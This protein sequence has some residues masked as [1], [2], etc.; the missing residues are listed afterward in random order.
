MK[1]IEAIVKPFR[2]EAVKEALTELGVDGMTMLDVK[3]FGR[4]FGHTEIYR[5]TEYEVDFVPK[6]MIIVVVPD[7]LADE[8]IKAILKAAKTGKIGDGKIFVSVL[9]EVIRIRTKETSGK[10]I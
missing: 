7:E 4:Q 8:A 10:S 1:K 3:G 2:V 9:E 5:G 6:I